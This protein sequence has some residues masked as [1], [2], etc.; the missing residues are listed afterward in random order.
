MV[1]ICYEVWIRHFVQE[2]DFQGVLL[3][4]QSKQCQKVLLVLLSVV[5]VAPGAVAHSQCR[6]RE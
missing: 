6:L 2:T 1:P 5:S 4:E 3:D